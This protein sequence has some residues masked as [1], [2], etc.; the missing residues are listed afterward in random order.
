MR[1]LIIDDTARAE[2]ARVVAHAQAHP[3]TRRQLAD[4][5]ELQRAPI[6]DDPAHVAMIQFGFRCVFSIED[7]PRGR[8][9]HLSVSV[10]E[11]GRLPTPAAILMLADAFGFAECAQLAR[12]LGLSGHAPT[13]SRAPVILSLGVYVYVEDARAINVLEVIGDGDE[14]DD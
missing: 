11:A 1:P 7:Q 4:V 14:H 2:I 10:P 8:M 12:M 13:D 9:R 3:L 5:V 6:G